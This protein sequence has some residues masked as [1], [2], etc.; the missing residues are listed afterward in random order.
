MEC[1]CVYNVF[2]LPFKSLGHLKKK[3][4]IKYIN[5][6]LLFTEDE[7][8]IIIDIFQKHLKILLSFIPVISVAL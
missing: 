8:R 4:Y 1:V 3:K 7:Q 6:I 2:H 5:L